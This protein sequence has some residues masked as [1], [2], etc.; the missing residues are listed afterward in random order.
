MSRCPVAFVKDFDVWHVAAADSETAV[1]RE[2]QRSIDSS[3][4][5][6]EEPPMSP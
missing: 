2:P 4:E 1:A 3:C 5:D 6:T